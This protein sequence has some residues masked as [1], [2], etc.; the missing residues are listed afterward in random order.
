MF[1]ACCVSHRVKETTYLFSLS[2]HNSYGRLGSSYCD[3]VDTGMVSEIS[4]KNKSSL[5]NFVDNGSTFMAKLYWSGTLFWQYHLHILI[6][7]P[8][9]SLTLWI[10][11]ILV[12]SFSDKGCCTPSS[13]YEN[14]NV[15]LRITS[16]LHDGVSHVK[17]KTLALPEH[18]VSPNLR[19][20]GG[21]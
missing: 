11:I 20:N 2:L 13:I 18:M 4:C 12:R 9:W 5:K 15:L 1:A 16:G 7:Y 17:Q 6:L 10:V 14:V 21:S 8:G 3:D 19:F